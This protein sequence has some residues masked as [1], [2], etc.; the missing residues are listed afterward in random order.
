M[1]T[2]KLIMLVTLLVT[3]FSTKAQVTVNVNIGPPPVWAPAAPAE[4]RYYYLPDIEVYYDVP[5]HN[6]IYLNGGKW[7]HSAALPSRY[8]GYDLY[9]GQTVYLNDYRGNTPYTYYRE[10]KEKYRGNS[11]WKRYKH[12]N[13]N[14]NGDREHEDHDNGNHNGNW[15]HEDHDNGNHKEKGRGKGHDD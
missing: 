10:H 6:Y 5:A 12:D 7:C 8:R 11:D 2:T 1:K 13:G 15:K 3:A 9:H 4:V 14:H